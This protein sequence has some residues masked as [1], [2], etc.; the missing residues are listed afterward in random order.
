MELL[1]LP[2]HNACPSQ[3]WRAPR[4]PGAFPEEAPCPLRSAVAC[5]PWRGSTAAVA[6]LQALGIINNAAQRWGPAQP[7]VTLGHPVWRLQLAALWQRPP[8]FQPAPP[9]P[10]CELGPEAQRLWAGPAAHWSVEEPRKPCPFVPP[11]GP[12]RLAGSWLSQ[13]RLE[14]AS[15]LSRALTRSGSSILQME[16]PSPEREGWPRPAS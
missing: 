6:Q 4:T 2:P 1:P 3:L 5:A 9:L 13:S 8:P 11:P 14:R 15:L 7:P 16:S 12:H 10:L